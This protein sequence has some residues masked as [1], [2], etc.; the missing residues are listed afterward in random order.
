MQILFLIIKKVF[1]YYEIYKK[2]LNMKQL[3]NIEW[4]LKFHNQMIPKEC[5]FII[6]WLEKLWKNKLKLL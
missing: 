5:L 6:I 3:T 2:S 4:I 1:N